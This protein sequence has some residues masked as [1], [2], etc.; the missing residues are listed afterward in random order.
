SDWKTE[1]RSNRFHYASRFSKYL[2][3][4]FVQPD[5]DT[6][7]ASFEDTEIAGVKILHVSRLYDQNQLE[8]LSEA[9][10]SKGVKRPL[11]WTYNFN[12]DQFVS[13]CYSPLKV[14][15]ATEDYFS[16]ELGSSLTSQMRA[17]RDRMLSVIDLLV[18]VS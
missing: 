16:K 10:R 5:L 3:V 17:S 15:H 12:F 6:S 13:W 4:Y 2:P 9:L 7:E 11:L 1:P 14:F 18:A 8:S